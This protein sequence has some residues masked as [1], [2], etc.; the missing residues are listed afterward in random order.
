VRASWRSWRGRTA[1]GSRWSRSCRPRSWPGPA[2]S[3]RSPG[4]CSSGCRGRRESRGRRSACTRPA[5]SARA[6]RRRW[7]MADTR[8]P[9][10]A[11]AR[12]AHGH[13]LW[14]L[15]GVYALAALWPSPGL[16]LRD[17]S[18]GTLT[19]G[20]QAV[21]FSL[22]AVLLVFLLFNAGLGVRLDRARE[23]LR[24]P[25]LLGTGLAANL[26]VPLAFT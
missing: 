3:T 4:G 8:A 12:F 24:R 5:R 21:R 19:L 16:R 10:A 15:V 25:L 20:G 11:A 26:V 13:L 6:R 9:I 1:V 2:S 23:V 17:A 22:P 18:L 7:V 14:F